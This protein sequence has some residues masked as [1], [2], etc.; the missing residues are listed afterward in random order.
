MATKPANQLRQV[1]DI[2]EGVIDLKIVTARGL[3]GKELS[4]FRK[5]IDA[6][7]EY[8]ETT[9]Q[10][11]P[12]VQA[13]R[14]PPKRVMRSSDHDWWLKLCPCYFP[15]RRVGPGRIRLAQRSLR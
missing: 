6:V 9:R 14:L 12:T 7:E 5:V 15:R 2:R 1:Y 4:D 13:E 3:S 8:V 10:S 11:P